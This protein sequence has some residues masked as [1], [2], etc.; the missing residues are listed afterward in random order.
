MAKNSESDSELEEKVL[1]TAAIIMVSDTSWESGKTHV[2]KQ[3]SGP[4]AKCGK[5]LENLK[6]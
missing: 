4:I 1:E 2:G 5:V 3:A 6:G